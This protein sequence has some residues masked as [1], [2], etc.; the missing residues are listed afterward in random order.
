M[1]AEGRGPRDQGLRAEGPRVEGR[2]T[3]G[4]GPR[5]EGRGTQTPIHKLFFIRHEKYFTFFSLYF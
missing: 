1:G 5:A 4:R 2:G 3:E